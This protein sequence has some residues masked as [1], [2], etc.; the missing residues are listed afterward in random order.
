[1]TVFSHI[2]RLSLIKFCLFVWSTAVWYRNCCRT[3][4]KLHFNPR[5]V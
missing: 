5:T 3:S 1:M 2:N 4:A